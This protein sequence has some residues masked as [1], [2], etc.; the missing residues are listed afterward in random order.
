M[1][2]TN[3]FV[4]LFYKDDNDWEM[5]S[6]FENPDYESIKWQIE[7]LMKNWEYDIDELFS[8]LIDTITD[9]LYG[10]N[11]YEDDMFAFK[12]EYV[13]FFS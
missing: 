5:I 1:K 6:V 8:E 9:S 2:H 10:D 13:P 7:R 3:D 11:Y 12:I 4:V